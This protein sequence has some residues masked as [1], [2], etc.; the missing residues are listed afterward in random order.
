M[1]T[2]FPE[3]YIRIDFSPTLKVIIAIKLQLSYR[4]MD[5]IFVHIHESKSCYYKKV[6]VVK[7][8]LVFFQKTFEILTNGN[9]HETNIS[10]VHLTQMLLEMEK[11]E[12]HSN[13]CILAKF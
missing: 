12:L 8:S 3:Q 10:Y 5:C 9:F 11:K 1:Y 2:V 13:K 7:I 4:E 6:Q